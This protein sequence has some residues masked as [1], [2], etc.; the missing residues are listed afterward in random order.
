M[1][2]KIVRYFTI[3]LGVLVAALVLL[4]VTVSWVMKDRADAYQTQDRTQSSPRGG[5][6]V[7]AADS[8]IFV[9]RL[10]DVQAPAVVFIHGTG[11]WSETWRASMQTAVA[12]GYQAYA[13]DLPPFGYSVPPANGDYS[14]PMQ[15][16]RLLAAIDSLKLKK[17]V[18]V[19]HSFG[20]APVAE[21]LLMRPEMANG[22]IL[23]DAALG[24]DSPQTD[25]SDTLLQ[26]LLRTRWASQTISAALLTNPSMTHKLL[27]SFISEKDKATA[28]W[29]AL[30][31]QPLSLSGSYQHIALWLPEL[32]SQRGQALSD[33][34]EPYATLPFPVTMIWGETDTITPLS[35]AANL[36]RLIPGSTLLVLPKAGHIPQ[37]EEPEQFQGRLNTALRAMHR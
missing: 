3:T 37:I 22:L 33:R 17:A 8:R 12:A 28:Q 1:I 5:V 7:D 26:S 2:R 27:Q 19:A 4:L 34:R 13:I 18:F 23:V 29:V 15:A 20:A 6:H 24:L 16:R 14:K 30:Y 35:Q 10:G 31:R 21:A 25:G 32:V 11:S 36:Q 9:Q